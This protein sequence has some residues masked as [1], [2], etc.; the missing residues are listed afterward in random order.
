MTWLQYVLNGSMIS[1]NNYVNGTPNRRQM[2][3]VADWPITENT[4]PI[5]NL[6]Y[7]NNILCLDLLAEIIEPSMLWQHENLKLRQV[8]LF[9]MLLINFM[10]E[11]RQICIWPK[12]VIIFCAKHAKKVCLP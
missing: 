7:R 9:R 4:G 3:I 11:L 5:T 1:A 8:D 10:A 12:M 6:G 2:F